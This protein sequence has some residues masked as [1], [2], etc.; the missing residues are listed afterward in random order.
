MRSI[1]RLCGSNFF[2][3]SAQGM[4]GP[5]AI[6]E[7]QVI[8][9]VLGHVTT[10]FMSFI[11]F[12]VTKTSVWTAAFG[13]GRGGLEVRVTKENMKSYLGREEWRERHLELRVA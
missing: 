8:A 9:R 4:N 7:L 6:Q 1:A 2:S 10:L 5:G 3:C 13:E 12:P 11:T